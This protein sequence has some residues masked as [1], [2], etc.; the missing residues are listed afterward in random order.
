[1]TVGALLHWLVS[2]CLFI[3]EVAYTWQPP[4]NLMGFYSPLAL[5][6]VGV[7]AL[8]LVLSLIVYSFI[9]AFRTRMPSMAGLKRR[10]LESCSF[11][12]ETLPEKGIAWGDI[13]TSTEWI[14]G[15]GETVGPIDT[16]KTYKSAS[17]VNAA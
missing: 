10:I 9:P 4:P 13:S 2:Q 11:L 1:M 8:V 7:Y 6:V 17:E 15:F 12:P 5:I 16:E 14:A 3:V